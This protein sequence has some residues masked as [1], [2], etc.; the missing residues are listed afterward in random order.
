[1]ANEVLHACQADARMH[2]GLPRLWRRKK[3]SVPT[4]MRDCTTP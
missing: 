2:D 4:R 3:V 1:V